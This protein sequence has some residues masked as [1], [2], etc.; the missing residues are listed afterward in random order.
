MLNQK[1]T[2]QEGDR[3]VIYS[4]KDNMSMLTL[5]AGGQYNS[6]YGSYKH[7]NIIGKEYG[8]KVTSDNSNGFVHVVGM[9]PELWSITLDHRTQILFNLDISTIIF[10]LE[11]KN[12]SKVV[13]SGTGSGSLSSSIARTVAP[14]GHLFT[15][16]FHEER[17]KAA[18][19]DFKENGLDK[20]ITVT[21]RDACGKEGFR[22]DDIEG[23]VGSIDA[24]FL[25][26]P[27]P[28]DAVDNAVAV[29][30]HGSML[31]SFSPCIEQVQKTCIK[32]SESKFQEI[33][34]VEVLIRTFD[35]RLQEYEELDLAN[36]YKT[37]DYSQNTKKNFEIGG[38]KG[39]KNDSLLS[40]PFTEARG[41]TGYLSFARYL[42]SA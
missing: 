24:V 40:K 31:C 22:R 21:H 28:W 23:M 4:G 39:Y 2:I 42:P 38:I 17:V 25:D 35:T 30:H 32:L 6:K 41:H 11:I 7:K 36:P 37:N 5:E 27:S 12:G 14:K 9:T 15:F 33:K 8:S 19:K 20:Y 3:V 10:N 18:R 13:E 26:L 29:M 1:K 16:E 34:T